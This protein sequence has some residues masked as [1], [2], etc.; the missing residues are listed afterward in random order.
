VWALS[1]AIRSGLTGARGCLPVAFRETQCCRGTWGLAAVRAF[2]LT[3]A[4]GIL[5]RTGAAVASEPPRGAYSEYERQTIHEVLAERGLVL[6]PAPEGKIVEAVEV[7]PLPV[8]EARDRVPVWVNVLHVRTRA[9]VLRRELLLRTGDIY[10]QNRVDESARNLRQRP[11]LSVVLILP[12]KG[13]FPRTVRV[14]VITKDVWSLRLS[15]DVQTE[16]AS[17]RKLLLQPVEL[18]LFGLQKIA[19]GLFTLEPDVYSLG[20]FYEDP[21]IGGTWLTG[22]AS[23]HA[24]M[25][26]KTSRREGSFGSFQFGRPLYS[27]RTRWGWMVTA[28]WRTEVERLFT[29]L[30]QRLFDGRAVDAR[31]DRCRFG[32]PGCLPEEYDAERIQGSYEVVRSYGHAIKVNLSGGVEA[33]RR[34]YST[35]RLHR[36]EPSVVAE[37]DEQDVPVSDTRLSPFLQVRC[38]DTRFM[39]VLDYNTLGLQE[40]VQLGHEVVLRVYPASRDVGSSR[41]MLG[42]RSLVSYVLPL[43]DGLAKGLIGSTIEYAGPRTDA[44]VEAG[45]RVVTPSTAVGRLVGDGIVAHRYRDYLK[46]NYELGGESRLRGYPST[47]FIG[48]DLVAYNLEFRSRPVQV[49]TAQLGGVLFYDIGDAFEGFSRMHLKDSVG[50]GVRVLFPQLDRIVFRVDWGLP[51][52]PPISSLTAAEQGFHSFPGSLFMTFGQA[53]PAPGRPQETTIR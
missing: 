39:H 32:V 14:V 23:V 48:K 8:F 43:G 9:H 24:I 35:S 12:V 46:T 17:L 19:G 10:D 27:L 45:F 16:N 13:R 5:I 42:S 31:A 4:I 37:F 40:D 34:R 50:A 2:A 47:E 51:L 49:V 22:Y 28:S 15:W 33:D 7:V 52:E 3:L 36:F 18:N 29:G 26:R 44:L 11:Q 30:E 41:D 25:N 1:A 20:G 6:D 21:R 38:F 53:F